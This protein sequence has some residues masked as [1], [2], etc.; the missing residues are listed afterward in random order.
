MSVNDTIAVALTVAGSDSGGGAGI[1]ADLKTFHT[2]GVFGTT[3]LT[4]IT[5]QNPQR[6]TGVQAVRP[7]IVAG[8][9]DR[10]L[11]AFRV[12]GAKTGMLYSAAIIEVVADRFHRRQFTKL[13]VDPVMVATSGARLLK[14]N[15]VAALQTRLFACGAVV[16]PNLVEAEILAGHTICNLEEL[17][18]AARALTD[19]HGVPFLVKGGHLRGVKRAVDVLCDGHRLH[20]FSAPVVRG[21]QTHGTG[22]TYSAAIAANL[23]LGYRLAEAVGRAK[24]LVTRAIR[25]AVRIGRFHALK[26]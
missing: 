21:I 4:A 15:A 9:I 10:V 14:R 23:A 6:V 17:R 13:V 12:G 7:E 25:D 19:R 3:A 5:C 24:V 8:Q 11:E 22:C 1:Q 18:N 2:L 26:I 20:E 16:T